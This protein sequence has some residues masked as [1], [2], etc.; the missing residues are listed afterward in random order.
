VHGVEGGADQE[1]A[2]DANAVRRRDRQL[3]ADLCAERERTLVAV[4]VQI[5]KAA[6]E[7]APQ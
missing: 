4:V 5:E 7:R 2:F 1:E 3:R 6:L